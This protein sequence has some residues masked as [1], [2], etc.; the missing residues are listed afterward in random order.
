M[1]CGPLSITLSDIYMAKMDKDIVEKPQPKF[2]KC[3]VDDIINCPKKNQVDLLF[4]DLVNYHQSIDLTLE[5]NP[6]RFL[7]INIEFQN[8]ILSGHCKE[9]KLP[10]P[11]NSKMPKCIIV[12]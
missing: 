11:W 8:G 2:Y 1:K 6:K 5:L 10:T 9:I 4:N 3:Y 7:S 12:M